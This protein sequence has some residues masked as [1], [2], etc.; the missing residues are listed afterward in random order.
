MKIQS[1]SENSNKSTIGEDE[2]SPS[3]NHAAQR[4]EDKIRLPVMAWSQVPPPEPHRKRWK[5]SSKLLRLTISSWKSKSKHEGSEEGENIDGKGGSWRKMWAT[6][7]SKPYS[8]SPVPTRESQVCSFLGSIVQNFFNL[9]F[10]DGVYDLMT[11]TVSRP[12]FGSLKVAFPWSKRRFWLF[13]LWFVEFGE[14][15]LLYI[16]FLF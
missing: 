12:V 2:N 4:R 9:Y 3:E 15:R 8:P 5:S 16:L 14:P 10:N 11:C 13:R 1:Q 7:G 6:E